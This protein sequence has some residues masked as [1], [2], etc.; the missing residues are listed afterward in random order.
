ME[1]WIIFAIL[2]MFFA[3]MYNFTLS[4]RNL[5]IRF[6]QRRVIKKYLI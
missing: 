3:G 4:K 2:S 6:I 1:S 5:W